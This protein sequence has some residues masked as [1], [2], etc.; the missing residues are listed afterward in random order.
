[1]DHALDTIA[2]GLSASQTMM[3]TIADNLSN[4]NTTGFKSETP[5]FQSL[6][7]QNGIQPGAQSTGQTVYPSGLEIGTGVKVAAIKDTMTQGTLAQTGNP[8]DMAINGTGYFQILQPNGQTVYTRDGSF[9]TNQSGQLVNSSGYQVLPNVTIPANAT[10]VTVGTDG[11][12]SITT[13]GTQVATQVGQ[14][15]LASFV[16]PQGLQPL[17]GNLFAATTASGAATAGA[18]Q[19]NGL[20]STNQ[21]YLESSNVDVVQAMVNMISAERAYQLGTQVASAVDNQL[22]YL[23]QAASGA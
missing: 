15:Q 18:P 8:Y 5:E 3:D 16:N 10:S 14:L 4:V 17:G 2:T 20:G 23:A 1:M 12:V 19:T 21:N 7:Y 11:T 9:Q 6:L 22:N 13:P